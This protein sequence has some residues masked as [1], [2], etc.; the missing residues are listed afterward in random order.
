MT[1]LESATRIDFRPIS[2]ED[3]ALYDRLLFDGET[4]GCE[5]AFAN[6][7]SWGRT[8]IAEIDGQAV[9][10]TRFGSRYYYPFP[11]G[12]GDKRS[13]ID[14]ILSDSKA[15]NIPC[16][17][18]GLSESE[19][20]TLEG[21]YPNRFSFKYDEGLY[22]YV[23]LIDDLA[24]LKGK[25]YDGKRNHLKRFYESYP[26]F[27]ARPLDECDI[28]QLQSMVSD[29]YKSRLEA[30]SEAD[31]T[32][33]I[34]AIERAF[35][36]RKE[37]SIDGL[38]L[39][40]RDRVL[41]VTLGSLLSDDTFDVHFEKA[42]PDVVGGY[43]AINREFACY[44]RDKYPSVRFIDREEDMSIEGLRRAKRS[45]HPHHMT[46]KCRALAEDRHDL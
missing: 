44:I 5:F 34:A 3:K 1:Q 19:K 32:N 24:D 23:Y 4:R 20:E 41:A 9:L 40:D 43:A 37:L 36:Y 17:I 45:Y 28:S 6:L 31:F 46:K 30:D 7:F 16:Y 38:A 8:L 21:L 42:R 22:D 13:A 14:A 2:I 33:E 27:T 39:Y 35:K 11:L 18:I 26:D 25:K 10:Q 12:N 29:W 15:R